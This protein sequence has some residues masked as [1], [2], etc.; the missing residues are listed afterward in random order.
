VTFKFIV[1]V[2]TMSNS[3]SY[4]PPAVVNRLTR[5]VRDLLKSPFPVEV[6]PESG[7][8]TNLQQLTVR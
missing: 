8:P 3:S 1:A 6:D 4:L 2:T 5:E 7:L